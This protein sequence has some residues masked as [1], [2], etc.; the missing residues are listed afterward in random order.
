MRYLRH[1][2]LRRRLCVS[3]PVLVACLALPAPAS[4]EA[5]GLERAPRGL[6]DKSAEMSDKPMSPVTVGNVSGAPGQAIPL[7]MTVSAKPGQP[8]PNTYLVGLP[9]GARLADNDH[10]ETATDEK[11]AIDVTHWDLPRLSVMLPPTQA[12][13]YTLAVVAASRP[14]NDGPL[15]FTSSTFILKA[16]SESRE[17]G[18]TAETPAAGTSTLETPVSETKRPDTAVERE[19]LRPPLVVPPSATAANDKAV[20]VGGIRSE[21]TTPITEAV[22]PKVLVKLWRDETSSIGAASGA[23]APP[24]PR[25]LRTTKLSPAAVPTAPSDLAA[26]PTTTPAAIAPPPTVAPPAA[27]PAAAAPAA[28]VPPAVAPAAVVPAATPPLAAAEVDGKALVERAERLIRLGDISGARLVLERASDRGDP[29]AIFLLAQ[30]CDPRMLRAWK[31]QGLKPDPDRARALYAKAAQEGV[32]E[33]KPITDA[34][35]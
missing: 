16:T 35:R 19:A 7:A 34:G 12:G 27:A 30:T 8:V 28:V 9:K 33:T 3:F 4:A 26:L 15:N 32:R 22:R 21:I 29:R 10:A 14:D 5:T 31:V 24:G 2:E 25:D 11:A 18:S 13:T 1:P 17:A 20:Q 23:N 6:D